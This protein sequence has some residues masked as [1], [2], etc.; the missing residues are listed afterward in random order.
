MQGQQNI[1]KYRITLTAIYENRIQYFHKWT[2]YG[3]T[4]EIA[5]S[6]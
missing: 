5:Y 2:K 6:I 1:K 4:E 3:A